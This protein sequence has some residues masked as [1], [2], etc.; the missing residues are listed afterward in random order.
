MNMLSAPIVLILTIVMPGKTPDEHRQMSM[1]TIEE[2][3]VQA[4]EWDERG[5]TEEMSAKGAIAVVG[6]CLIKKGDQT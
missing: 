1:P 5:V 2:C 6:A 4:K 3:F